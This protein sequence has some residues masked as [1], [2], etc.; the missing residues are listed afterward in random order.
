MSNCMMSPTHFIIHPLLFFFFLLFP[1]AAG[2]ARP[3][4]RN[5]EGGRETLRERGM[6][7]QEGER[8]RAYIKAIFSDI[9]ALGVE[10][11]YE[12]QYEPMERKHSLFPPFSL[13]YSCT[14]EIYSCQCNG[15]SLSLCMVV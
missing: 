6:E 11:H 2:T 14:Q 1:A 15:Q 8:M 3:A 12:Y 5:K 13:G 10:S 7:R 4:N 9:C